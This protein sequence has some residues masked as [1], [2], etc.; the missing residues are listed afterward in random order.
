MPLIHIVDDDAHVRAATSYLLAS[1]GHPTEVYASAEEFLEQANLERGCVL[2]DLRMPGLDGLGTM[3]R[4]TERGVAIPT[5]MMTGHGDLSTAVQAMKLGAID[6]IEKPY[7]E[8][9]LLAAIGR[10]LDF[11]AQERRRTRGRS[12]ALARIEK[13]SPREV[14]ILQGLLGGLSNKAIARH[15]NL[16]HRTVEMHRARLMEDLGCGSLSEA[17]RIAIAIA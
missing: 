12:D 17:V 15:L 5:I 6:F 7:K 1:R 10:A 16:S 14:Q 8:Q 11:R 9:E 4:L 13:L 2:L 3:T